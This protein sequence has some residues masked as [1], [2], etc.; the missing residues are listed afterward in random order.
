MSSSRLMLMTRALVTVIAVVAVYLVAGVFDQPEAWRITLGVVVGGVALVIQFLIDF[1]QRIAVLSSD[2]TR[3]RHETRELLDDSFTRISQATELFG[4]VETSA[5][6]ADGV[7]RLVNSATNVASDAPV[8]VRTFAQEEVVRLTELLESMSRNV[9][10]REGEDHEWI[11]TLTQCTRAS[12]DGI[13]TSMDDHFWDSETGRRYLRAQRE[14]IQTRGV[15]VR[16]LF[17]VAETTDVDEA[18][19]RQFEN[20]QSLGIDVRVLVLASVPTPVRLGATNDFVVFDDELSYEVAFDFEGINATTTLNFLPE[21]V[22]QRVRRFNELWE[23][24]Q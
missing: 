2:L 1:D 17:L 18:L 5:L 13:S 10:D 8:I 7:V 15:R 3:N 23:V 4:Q 11:V 16:R 24:A 19:E 9:V 12:I 6:R 14:A 20:Q 21:R 22:R